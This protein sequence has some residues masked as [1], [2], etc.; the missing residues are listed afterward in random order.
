M[1][2]ALKNINNLMAYR[3]TRP[4]CAATTL[5][6]VG[7]FLIGMVAEFSQ[8]KRGQR[9]RLAGNVMLPHDDLCYPMIQ[10][11]ELRVAKT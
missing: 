1:Y 9:T 7:H 8:L 6:M 11:K 3:M 10:F 4:Y 2:K 5:R